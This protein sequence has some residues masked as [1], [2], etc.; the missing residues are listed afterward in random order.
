[1]P[2]RESGY[3]I[4]VSCIELIG[5]IAL[6]PNEDFMNKCQSLELTRKPAMTLVLS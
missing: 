2:L 6:I 3:K 5:A 4:A 1:M